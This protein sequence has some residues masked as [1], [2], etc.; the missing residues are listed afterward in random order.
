MNWRFVSNSKRCLGVALQPS[1]QQLQEEAEGGEGAGGDPAALDS[2]PP[3]YNDAVRDRA[4]TCDVLMS[5]AEDSVT[6][7]QELRVNS[8]FTQI[9]CRTKHFVVAPYPF[10]TTL[11][12][13]ESDCRT[14]RGW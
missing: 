14:Q 10:L 1:F 4:D 12:V 11:I 5:Q 2:P 3:A 6:E 9:S 8:H 13:N 7:G